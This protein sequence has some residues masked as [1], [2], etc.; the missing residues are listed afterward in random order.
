MKEGGT[1]WF[2]AR[3]L[4][5]ALGYADWELDLA[6]TSPNIPECCRS[7]GYEVPSPEVPGEPDGA[8]VL[9]SPVGV[10]YWT[11]ATDAPCGQN[12]AAWAKREAARLVPEAAKDDPRTFLTFDADGEL[13]PYPMKYS[14]RKGEW[15]ALRESDTY[16]W[17]GVRRAA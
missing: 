3:D 2:C 5:D 14:G 9:L 11:D 15:I 17:R 7:S 12:I 6:S 13:P 4:V 16:F 8:I 10:W 1:L